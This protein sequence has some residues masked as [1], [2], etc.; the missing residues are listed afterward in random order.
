MDVELEILVIMKNIQVR[1]IFLSSMLARVQ[2]M[3]PQHRRQ[4]AS[5]MFTCQDGHVTWET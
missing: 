2:P 1:T 5:L 3:F 4:T